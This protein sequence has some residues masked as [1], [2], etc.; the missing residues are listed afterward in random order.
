M[1]SASL[2]RTS[3]KPWLNNIFHQKIKSIRT[4][5]K[6]VF[7]MIRIGSRSAPSLHRGLG[8]WIGFETVRWID[9]DD[10]V[11]RQCDAA[12]H[13]T[14]TMNCHRTITPSNHR[15][16]SRYRPRPRRYAIVNNVIL[17]GFHTKGKAY[18]LWNFI[19]VFEMEK[20][21]LVSTLVLWNCKS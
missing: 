2:I 3:A 8:W 9:D 10:A 13:G 19:D 21:I 18:T 4:C 20:N 14:M 7:F 1:A 16:R 15:H 11:E 17:C 5:Q 12:M 6:F